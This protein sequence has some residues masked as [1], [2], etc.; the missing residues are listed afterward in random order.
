MRHAVPN[1]PEEAFDELDQALDH[2]EGVTEEAVTPVGPSP[3]R[4]A[5][6]SLSFAAAIVVLAAVIAY[7]SSAI[8]VNRAEQHTDD[9]VAVLESDLQARRSAAAEQNA[10]RDA[11]IAELRRLVCLFADHATPRDQDVEDV[12]RRYGCTGVPNPTPGPTSSATAVPTA[13]PQGARQP[14]RSPAGPGVGGPGGQPT[15]A[16]HPTSTGTL[17]VPSKPVPPPPASPA[18]GPQPLVCITLPLLPP[19]C[20]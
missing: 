4:T 20:V 15:P 3:R 11:Q 8:A 10:N 12:R 13:R 1:E 5:L 6:L 14:V 2:A 19:L 9:R 18:G 17:T 16:P 7:F